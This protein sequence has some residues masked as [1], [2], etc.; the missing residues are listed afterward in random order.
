M[1]RMRDW[2]CDLVLRLG[3]SGNGVIYRLGALG[4][5]DWRVRSQGKLV[6]GRFL[7]LISDCGRGVHKGCFS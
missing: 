4:A 3:E 5:C 6:L 1:T 2:S 7:L